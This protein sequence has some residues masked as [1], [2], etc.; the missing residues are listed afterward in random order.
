MEKHTCT[1]ANE[2]GSAGPSKVPTAFNVSYRH[3]YWT[4]APME[5]QQWIY[6]VFYRYWF[7]RAR[8]I[9]NHVLQLSY[10]MKYSCCGVKLLWCCMLSVEEP[11]LRIWLLCTCF[12]WICTGASEKWVFHPRTAVFERSHAGSCCMEMLKPFTLISSTHAADEYAKVFLFK[13]NYYI[14]LLIK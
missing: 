11:V 8:P 2:K 13:Q 12:R 1:Y 14:P 5:I 10:P 6:W 9:F 4:C 3:C 7:K